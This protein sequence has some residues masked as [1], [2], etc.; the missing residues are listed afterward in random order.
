MQS[1]DEILRSLGSPECSA[2]NKRDPVQARWKMTMDAP[3]DPLTSTPPPPHTHRNPTWAC[4]NWH[5]S[6]TSRRGTRRLKDAFQLTGCAAVLPPSLRAVKNVV[7]A[8]APEGSEG[9][10]G[11]GAQGTLQKQQKL[12]WSLPWPWCLRKGCHGYRSL[13]SQLPRSTCPGWV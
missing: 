12:I 13:T 2:A 6:S 1:Q 8:Q 10:W 4:G 5:I 9:E 3:G 11:A 7:H